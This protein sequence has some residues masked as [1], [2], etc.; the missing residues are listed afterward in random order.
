[1]DTQ[2]P[3]G[4]SHDCKPRSRK[5]FMSGFTMLYLVRWFIGSGYFTDQGTAI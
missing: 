1:M 4:S 5:R 2:F 3:Q